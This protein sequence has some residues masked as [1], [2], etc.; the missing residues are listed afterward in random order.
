MG[1]G[2]D[3]LRPNHS[4]LKNA[5]LL[6]A[7]NLLLRGVSM[8]FQVYLSER[9]G[10]AGVGLLQLVLTVE[11]VAVTFGLS[12]AR[13]AAMYLCAE[14]YGRR[15]R[16]G[17][18][19]A[20]ACCLRYGLVCS[21]LAAA[22][23]WFGAEWAAAAWLHQPEAAE[24]LRMAALG[25]PAGCCCAI[26]SGYFTACGQIGRLVRVEVA[27]RLACVAL[28]MLLLVR[29]AG[30]SAARTCTAVVL[31]GNVT[32]LASCLLLGWYVRRGCRA[33]KNGPVSGMRR[34]MWK[35]CV[36]LALSDYLRSG[37]R[38]LEQL[39]IPWGLMRAGGSY[40]SA[41]ADYG[42]ICGMVFPVLMFPAALL[43]ALSDLLVPELAR[44]RAE[45]DGRRVRHLTEKCLRMGL[46]FS[47]CVAG[48]MFAL[49]DALGL[50]LYGR[51]E[52]GHYL[53]LF[54]PMIL[55]LYMDAI[56]DGTLKGLGEQVACARYNTCTTALDALLLWLLLP[57]YGLPVYLLSFSIS[58]L[59]NF[60]FSLRRLLR[61]T[62]YC[63]S[64]A[65]VWKTLVCTC[66]ASAAAFSVFGCGTVGLLL[67]RTALFAA[68]FAALLG[69]LE[70]LTPADV[71]WL[72]HTLQSRVDSGEQAG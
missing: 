10:A 52:V 70:L 50:L 55:S 44:C 18:R 63:P 40:E 43:F 36:P 69:L 49:A 21:L 59:V 57:R 14:E 13:V 22:A 34:R 27:E 9:I 15:S 26:L 60:A 33:A 8:L 23:L 68:V 39:L 32:T 17:V 53:R 2:G 25:L 64:L 58:H 5:L 35:L 38:T 41:M 20:M 62:D 19:S 31:G 6:T 67:G 3:R 11:G 65:H 16:D 29:S 56:V 46:L 47:G 66:A 4:I 54:A 1:R 48:L 28:T 42:L 61:V 37:L 12:G 71:R 24:S 45:A 30:Q 51:A 7:V 72:R